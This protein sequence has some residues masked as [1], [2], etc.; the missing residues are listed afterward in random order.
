[1][2]NQQNDRQQLN[3]LM[4]GWMHRDLGEWEQLN[5][6]FHPDGTIEITWFEGLGSDF[7]K[8][9]M[10]M[11]T[12]DLRTKHLIASPAVTFNANGDKAI[13]ETN[14]IIIAENV[15][16]NIGC[17]CHNRFYDLAEK[18]EGVW[19]LFRRQSI[20]DMGTFT[21]PLGPVEIDRRT[22]EKYPREY[23][24]LA[25]LLEQSGFP[26]GRV[27][28]TRGSELETK[29]KADAQRWLSA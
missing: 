22:A 2:R 5:E 14:A 24:A 8:G 17:E 4:N 3:D 27:F 6:L 1:M 10:R 26:L 7:V 28:A 21:F 23:A 13:L 19:K 20:Y 9:S 11:G 25:Y 18:R 15:K 29:M 12:S 16:L